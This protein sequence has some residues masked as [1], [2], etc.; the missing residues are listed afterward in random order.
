MRVDRGGR[1]AGRWRR[2]A[3]PVGVAGAHQRSVATGDPAL[4]RDH[5][6]DGRRRAA[7]R[8]SDARPRGA[9]ARAR[10]RGSQRGLR[11]A[12]AAPGVRAEWARVA[13]P[14]R[15]LHCGA[16]AGAAAAAARAPARGGG[17]RARDRGRAHAPRAGRRGDVRAGAVRAVSEAVRQRGDDRGGAGATEAQTAAAAP[18]AQAHGVDPRDPGARLHRPA[19]GPGRVPVPRRRRRDAVRRQVGLDSQPGA[20]ALR[21]LERAGGMDGPRL[22]RRLPADAL[23]AGRAGAREPADQGAAPA[24]QHPALRA[25]TTGS[26]TSAAGSTSPYPILEVATEP[27][28]GHA[29]D[30]RAAPRAAAGRRAGRAARLAVRP[31]PLRP[32]A[33]APRA[34]RPPTGRWAAA[35]RR[36][37]AISTRTCTG[38]ASTRRCGCSSTGRR[39]RS[40][41]LEHVEAADARG[42]GRAALRA[43]RVAAPAAAAA[44]RDPRP[45][46][47]RA[48]GH[49]RAAAAGAGAA[50][51]AAA[52]RRA[53]GWSAAG[54][55]TSGPL[56]D[57]PDEVTT[58]TRGAAL[59]RTGR[60]L[61]AHVPPDEIDEVRIVAT[62]LASHPDTPQL[63]LRAAARRR[64][65]TDGSSPVS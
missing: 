31:A 10:V 61:G 41:L 1:G 36:A 35:C 65:A 11:P 58:R 33:A 13:Q 60:E 8:G 3:R 47:R 37:S 38:A 59:V 20:R 17:R 46:R 16:G 30:D 6:G 50:S 44:A 5:A 51:G 32:A 22:D 34:S 40:R 26:S 39:G 2:A 4:H 25:A 18:D 43:R 45:S 15:D 53:S 54:W 62:Y 57:D 55:S 29:V 56:P 23:R 7:G 12:R 19:E 49:P 42:G 14:A 9:A 21:A 64:R 48:R 63:S 52:L 24:G 27:A 28:A